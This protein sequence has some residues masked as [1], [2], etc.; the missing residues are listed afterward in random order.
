MPITA[1]H[2][3]KDIDMLGPPRATPQLSHEEFARLIDRHQHPLH[4]YLAGLIGNSEQAFDLVQETFFEAWRAAQTGAPPFL[5]G[6]DDAEIR[7]WLFRAGSN[8]AIS[9]LRHG[10]LIRW[11]SLEDVQEQLL[12]ASAFEDHVA[13]TDALQA[14]LAQL[15]P[16]DVA[17]LLLRVVHGFSASEVGAILSTAPENVNNR[18][19][20]AKQ[21]LRAAYMLQS[22]TQRKAGTPS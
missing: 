11:E 9:L 15:A 2:R 1:S 20:R 17:C 13:E 7:R 18:L 8:N 12:G 19:A 10:R 21:R 3:G 22:P 6:T 14:A 4:V 5:C 16:Q